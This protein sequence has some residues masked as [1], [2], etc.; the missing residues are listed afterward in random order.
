MT[1]SGLRDQC[2]CETV[3]AIPG[4]LREIPAADLLAT[5]QQSERTIRFYSTGADL[6][7]GRSLPK[8]FFGNQ[9]P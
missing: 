5:S 4:G 9:Y 6:V 8:R 7:A 2:G 3:A 1:A